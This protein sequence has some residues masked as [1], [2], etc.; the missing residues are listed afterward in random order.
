MKNP[1]FFQKDFKIIPFVRKEREK[2]FGAVQGRNGY[3]VE[4]AQENIYPDD[5]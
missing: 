1:Y 4:N 2:D 5:H 3:E